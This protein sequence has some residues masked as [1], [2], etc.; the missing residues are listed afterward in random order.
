MRQPSKLSCQVPKGGPQPSGDV[1]QTYP[2]FQ[3]WNVGT[4][5]RLDHESQLGIKSPTTVTAFEDSRLGRRA[6]TK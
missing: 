5:M 4:Q 2:R 6:G 3:Y 1:C